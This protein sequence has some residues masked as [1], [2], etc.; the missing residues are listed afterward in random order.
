MKSFKTTKPQLRL[1]IGMTIAFGVSL[2]A[3]EYGKP[4]QFK[5]MYRYLSSNDHHV[6]EE[7]IPVTRTLPK[8]PKP[9]VSTAPKPSPP[10]VRT[11]P[12]NEIKTEENLPEFEF[13]DSLVYLPTEYAEPLDLGAIKLPDVYP[14]FPGGD[15]ALYK[16]LGQTIAYPKF[17]KENNIEGP[18][19]VQFVVERDGQID[20]NSIEILGSPHQALSDESIRAIRKMP[21]WIP[22]KQRFHNVAVSMKLPIK[23]YLD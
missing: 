22:G 12:D 21:V 20:P 8:P 15:E 6:D 23:F 4:K 14:Q 3:L 17:A 18:V 5:D 13:Q 11:R 1:L 19:Y 7:F 16:F 2:C 10:K 9:N